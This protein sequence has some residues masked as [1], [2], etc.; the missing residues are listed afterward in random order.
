MTAA[1][2]RRPPLC[3]LTTSSPLLA[4]AR[5]LNCHCSPG[6]RYLETSELME[7][8]RSTSPQGY[9]IPPPLPWS[10]DMAGG[11]LAALAR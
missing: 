1:D 8:D 5:E 10:C 11:A 9:G 6:T 3:V 2:V 7:L 4:S